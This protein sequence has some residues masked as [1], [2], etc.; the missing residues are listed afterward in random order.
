MSYTTRKEG[1]EIIVRLEGKK[2]EDLF[3]EGALAVFHMLY[4][5]DSIQEKERIKL[6]VQ[7]K[8]LPD[9][10]HAWIME[11]FERAKIQEIACGEFHVASIQKIDNS[12][13]LLTGTAYGEPFDVSRH[14]NA[15]V[16]NI[17]KIHISDTKPNRGCSCEAI[18]TLS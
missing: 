12:H 13:Y 11:L 3:S 9:L 16:K 17:S 14:G 7:A 2:I 10:F 4:D 18:I 5:T 6:V 15:K 1:N 8:N